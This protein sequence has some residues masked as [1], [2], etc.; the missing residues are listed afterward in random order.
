MD[1]CLLD[2]EEGTSNRDGLP[3]SDGG[4]PVGPSEPVFTDG[5]DID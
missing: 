1:I 5:G 2:C 3:T 4:E